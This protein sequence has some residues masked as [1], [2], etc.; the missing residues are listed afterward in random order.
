MVR[1]HT[2]VSPKHIGVGSCFFSETTKCGGLAAGI[3]PCF[4]RENVNL[5][6]FL[7]D[8]LSFKTLYEVFKSTFVKTNRTIKATPKGH[9]SV[10]LPDVFLE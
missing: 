3:S 1:P 6:P 10:G 4:F 9:S 8:V 2:L 5:E 7:S